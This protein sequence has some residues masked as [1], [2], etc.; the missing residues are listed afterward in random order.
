MINLVQISDLHIGSLFDNAKGSF[1]SGFN[2][3][4]VK[5]CQALMQF[6]DE[7]IYTIEGVSEDAPPYLL[8]NG[9]V[10]CTGTDREFEIADTYLFS[11][12]AIVK[13]RRTHFIGINQPQDRFAG[14]PGNHDHWNGSWFP[15]RQTGFSREIYERFFEPLPYSVSTVSSQ[16]IEVCIF[17]VDSCSMFD[18]SWA[19][20]SIFAN[21]GFSDEHRTQFEALIASTIQLPLPTNCFSRVAIIVCHHPFC[22]DGAAGP[23]LSR[24][25][26]WLAR[27]A[28]RNRIRLVFTGHTHKS[29]TNLMNINTEQG[30]MELR[31]VRCPT[32]LQYPARLDT[33]LRKPG[34]WLHQIFLDSDEVVARGALLLFSEDSFK[35]PSISNPPLSR[36]AVWYEERLPVF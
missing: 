16:G 9:D 10:T 1:I 2:A 4:D 31:E 11:R 5:L 19:N 32:T 7:D 21:G 14:I 30:W 29:W 25:A 13:N 26:E 12:H 20:V 27:L 22:R 17:S 36:R 35:I 15:L 6:L 34:L 8:V 28:A 23:L 33:A 3:H 18:S 24:S